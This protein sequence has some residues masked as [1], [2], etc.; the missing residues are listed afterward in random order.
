MKDILS[1]K[2]RLSEY[3]TVALTKE[4]SA[5]L[6]NKLPSKLK[7]SGSFTIPYN[8]GESYYGKALCDLG[9]SINLMP[10][11]TFKMLGIREV[12][13]TTVTLQLADSIFSISRRK[14][15]GCFGKS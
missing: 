2:K 3:E 6:Q 8:I 12:R 7:D 14:D 5:F 1:K 13:L 10:K 11:S 4:C 15:R 9:A